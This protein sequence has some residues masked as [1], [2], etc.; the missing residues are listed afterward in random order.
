MDKASFPLSRRSAL[1]FGAGGLIAATGIARATS[2]R[3]LLVISVDGMDHRYMRDADALGLKT[4]NLR[5]LTREGAWADG[6]V[7][8]YPTVT[9]PSHST[10]ITGVTPEVHGILNND[11]PKEEGGGRYWFRKYLKATPIYDAAKQAGMKTAA[12]EWPVTVDAGLDFVIPEVFEKRGAGMDMEAHEKHATPGLM[13]KIAA[14]YPSFPQEWMDDRTRTLAVLYLLKHERP[15]LLLVHLVDHDEEAHEAGPFTKRSKAK[16]EYVDELIGQMLQALPKDMCVALVSD[17]GFERVDRLADPRTLLAQEN[18]KGEFTMRGTLA[19]TNDPAVAVLLR[20]H[21]GEAA[22][23]LGREI[24]AG[25]IDRLWPTMKG[26]FVFEP[27]EH[28]LFGKPEPRG[29]SGTHG[30][31]PLRKDYRATF[32]MWGPGVKREKLPE[33][34]MLAIAGKLAEVLALDFPKK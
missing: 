7:G 18:V 33:M 11:R 31:W 27:M 25:E 10:I 14:A 9:W 20:R 26:T 5:K 29:V 1:Q 6:V 28:V 32:A 22:Y 21:L 2:R 8:V 23:G 4:P 13:D 17:H 34:D 19:W 24:P 16:L 15:D 3:K 30:Y 12:V